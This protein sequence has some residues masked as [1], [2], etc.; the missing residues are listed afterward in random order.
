MTTPADTRPGMVRRLVDLG[1]AVALV[2]VVAN[3]AYLAAFDSASIA[4]HVMVVAHLV[5]GIVLAA[6]AALRGL[7]LLMTRLRA[8]GRSRGRFS[9]SPRSRRSRRSAPPC[10]SP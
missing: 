4:Y 5:A 6:L 7:P 1:L 10:G 9:A 3:A 8:G 2:F